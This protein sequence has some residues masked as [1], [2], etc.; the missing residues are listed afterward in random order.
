MILPRRGK[1]ILVRTWFYL[2]MVN[3]QEKLV[4]QPERKFPGQGV[5]PRRESMRIQKNQWE[6]KKMYQKLWKTKK[7]F[8]K[9]W[10]LYKTEKVNAQQRKAIR[11]QENRRKTKKSLW[12]DKPLLEWPRDG[13]KLSRAAFWWPSQGASSLE[14]KGLRLSCEALVALSVGV[15]ANATKSKG[16]TPQ[17]TGSSFYFLILAGKN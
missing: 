14:G 7:H 11:N 13:E 4:L 1:R 10:K 16:K 6:T 3:A 5:S 17:C 2:D 15:A 8:Q 12:N 9:Q